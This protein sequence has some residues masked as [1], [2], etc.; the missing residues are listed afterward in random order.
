MLAISTIDDV[1]NIGK[2]ARGGFTLVELLVAMTVFGLLLA[3]GVPNMTRW[4]VKN[5][6]ASA[7]EFYADGFS[8]ARRTA[9]SRNVES[10]ISLIPNSSNGQLDWE[11]DICAPTAAI[12]CSDI[13]GTWS[14]VTTAVTGTSGAGFLSVYRAADA[15]PQ[16]S[17]LVPSLQPGGASYIYFTPLGWVDTNVSNRVTRIQ[18]DPAPAYTAD[19]PSSAVAVTLSGMA[20]TCIPSPSV[21]SSD[22][23]AC[24]P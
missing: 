19:I 11:V 2:R 7:A 5:K 15:L 6:A 22:S 21:T 18:F 9:V 12:A 1:G 16:S 17:V 10:R 23:R 4:I 13:S 3:I 20:S 24:P 14:T 8:T